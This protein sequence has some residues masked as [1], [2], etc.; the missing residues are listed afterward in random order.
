MRCGITHAGTPTDLELQVLAVRCGLA[1]RIK[2]SLHPG[3]EVKI[4]DKQRSVIAM[5]L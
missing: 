1:G 2:Y 5:L 3:S 4:G